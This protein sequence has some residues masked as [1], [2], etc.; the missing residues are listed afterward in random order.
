MHGKRHLL[1]KSNDFCILFRET[2]ASRYRI[3]ARQEDVTEPLKYWARSRSN[4][5]S[6]SV[7]SALVCLVGKLSQP[8][9]EYPEQNMSIE[10]EVERLVRERMHQSVNG[11][12]WE[13]VKRVVGLAS[14]LQR[15]EGGDLD[16]I[17]LAAL[18][19]DVGDAKLHDG[20]ERGEELGRE[21][22]HEAG[23]PQVQI[24][25]IIP[26]V[27]NLSFRNRH[28]MVAMEIEGQIVQ[29]ADRLDAIGAIGI[30]R[31]IEYGTSIGEA[32][33]RLD[34]ETHELRFDHFDEKLLKLHSMM[35][36]ETGRKMAE[37][38]HEF[39]KIFLTRF[40]EEYRQSDS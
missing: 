20:V 22:L 2:I 8:Q 28:T 31:T 17:R 15:S 1:N 24:E 7:T 19:H 33:Y 13:H 34:R 39:M 36:T 30:V 16:V 37:Q 5:G 12:D 29:D 32:I 9:T 25:S 21:I 11:H 27:N 23:V 26:I 6:Q 35:N 40:R 10:E 14:Q 4:E 3:A 38:R 18:V